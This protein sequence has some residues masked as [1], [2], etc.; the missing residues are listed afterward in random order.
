M[1]TS[2]DGTTYPAAVATRDWLGAVRERRPLPS[3]DQTFAVHLLGR[4]IQIRLSQTACAEAAQLT[5]P[6]IVEMELYFSCLVRK[7]VRFRT[8]G[9]DAEP[10]GIESTRLYDNLSL[11][12][13]PVTT[14]HCTLPT[15][16]TA[17]PLEAMPVARP[18]AFVPHWLTIDFHRGEW[19]GEF[20]Y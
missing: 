1:P 16:A 20:G 18:Q 17:P 5:S 19:V 8:E 11:Q 12:F 7:A 4:P 13:R 15:D 14:Q 3:A 6:L 9:V 10:A 2:D